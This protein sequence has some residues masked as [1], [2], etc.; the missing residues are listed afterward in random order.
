MTNKSSGY[1]Q[2]QLI[3]RDCSNLFNIRCTAVI[4]LQLKETIILPRC[5]MHGNSIQAL[6]N[7][8]ARVCHNNEHHVWMNASIGN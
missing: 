8:Y 1:L 3:Y 6:G 2:H 7:L 4:T 5:H